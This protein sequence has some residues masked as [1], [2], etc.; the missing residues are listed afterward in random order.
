[1]I[2]LLKIITI[3]A[4]AFFLIGYCEHYIFTSS[5]PAEME[6]QH[7]RTENSL[8]GTAQART[9]G[10]PDGEP[11]ASDTGVTYKAEYPDRPIVER[12]IKK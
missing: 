5:I 10:E 1:M 9:D 11:L 3:V 6:A 4:V 2:K 7:A 8:L 12:K